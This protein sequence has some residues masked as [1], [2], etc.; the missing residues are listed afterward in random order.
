MF[1]LK[2]IFRFVQKDFVSGELNLLL[3][4]LVISVA[5][6]STITLFSD[7]LQQALLIESS[8]LLAADLAISSDE[9]INDREAL[10]QV[11]SVPG[12][13]TSRT[14]SFLT[15]MFFGEQAQ[16]VS[17]K[18][19]DEA[20]PLRGVLL[21]GNKPFGDAEKARSVP[22]PGEIW[23]ESRLFPSLDISI[24]RSVEIG[25]AAL[26]VSKVLVRQPDNFGGFES[27]APRVLINVADLDRTE[28]LQPGSRVN[29]RYLI[30]GDPKVIKKIQ[31]D[32]NRDLP[33]PMRVITPKNASETL[34]EAI[35]RGERILLL[36]SL[37]TVI[38]CGIATSFSAKRYVDRHL[39]HIAILKTL[40]ASPA[41]VKKIFL[42]QFSLFSV[43]VGLLGCG[44]GYGVQEMIF[45]SLR[46]L[47]NFSL[48]QPGPEPIFV[49][50]FMSFFCLF[51]F[52][53]FPILALA[54]A[55]PMRVLRKSNE[56]Y[57]NDYRTYVLGATG[58]LI[59]LVLFSLDLLLT[60]VLF[61][62]VLITS[63]V[64]FLVVLLIIKGMSR[65]GARAGSIWRLSLSGLKKRAVQSSAQVL[66]FGLAIMMFLVLFILRTTLIEDWQRNIP[67]DAPNHF[68]INV[69]IEEIDQV[70]RRLD[71]LSI[72]PREFFP[73]IRGLITHLNDQS[74]TEDE[75]GTQSISST[76]AR[77]REARNLTWTSMLP[78]GNLVVDGEW[79]P[80]DYNGPPLM[81]VEER[82]AERNNLKVKD[83]VTVLIQG[84]SV[85]AQISSIRSVDWDNFQPNFFLIFSPGSLNEFSSTYMTS[86]FLKQNQKLLLN[87]LLRDFPSLTILELDKIIETIQ[88]I[89]RYIVFAVQS[90][91]ILMLLAAAAVLVSSLYASMDERLR[92][93]SLIR[94]F[95]ASRQQILGSLFIEFLMIG[96]LSGVTACVGAEIIVLSLD[97]T[98]FEINHQP[99]YE[100]LVWVPLQS[101]LLVSFLG[102]IFVRQI[103]FLPPSEVL[104][105]Y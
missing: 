7:R 76:G 71:N 46:P 100:L 48:P 8:S 67:D 63:I 98:I 81:S 37:L 3:V 35:G 9:P 105:E 5:A 11:F 70:Q 68:V 23:L 78:A 32:L 34:G 56:L 83:K 103:I 12:L 20:Y 58:I 62:G 94:A 88:L 24:G 52:A 27:A 57:R 19:V 89:I 82:F 38:L 59:L 55:Q 87:S 64:F 84:S 74:V 10:P 18:A 99:N 26:T 95:G 41:F 54:N 15:M 22:R 47:F 25:S 75:N 85:N 97:A 91:L 44:L 2:G 21:S 29:F 31:Q 39:D 69:S 4:S 77:M 17:V 1:N 79:W 86:F 65:L 66:V 61:F 16:L 33:E 102:M 40:G 13:M 80:S 93:H 53:F 43:L 60:L 36:G 49:G 45:S 30:A 90:L 92:Q 42:I 6:V 73:M 50:F 28:V 96:F 104:R 51:S 101:S 72:E 14:A